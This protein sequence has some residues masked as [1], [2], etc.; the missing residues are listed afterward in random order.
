MLAMDIPM[1][2]MT[3]LVMAEAGE[4]ILKQQ[5]HEKNNFMRI[6]VA[7][8]MGVFFAPNAV[9]YTLGWPA[10]EVNYLWPGIDGMKD[11]PLKAGFSHVL[12]ALA[13]LPALG[14]LELGRYWI[15][16]GKPKLVRYG[17]IF[18][19]VLTIVAICFFGHQTFNVAS[20]YARYKAGDTY[21]FMNIP[22]LIGWAVTAAYY[23]VALFF[24]YFWLKK[25]P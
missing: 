19:A 12:I 22:M 23:W 16:K 5:S 20:T 1:A 18:F 6:F 9:Y 13:V 3:G 10:W 11:N 24:F 7:M 17:Y 15:T 2:A 21:S 4:Q 8:F 14:G 25:N